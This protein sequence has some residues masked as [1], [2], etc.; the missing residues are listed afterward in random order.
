MSVFSCE[1][2]HKVK[3]VNQTYEQKTTIHQGSRGNGIKF[4]YKLCTDLKQQGWRSKRIIETNS[5]IRLAGYTMSL[6]MDLS[7]TNLKIYP[8]ISLH[9]KMILQRQTSIF[10]PSGLAG[11]REK[12][13]NTQYKT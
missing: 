12:G 2:W 11:K 6:Y 3:L 8:S 13:E 7:D 9:L 10:I 1:W 5:V 4:S